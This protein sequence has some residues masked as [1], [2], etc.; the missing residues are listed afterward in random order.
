MFEKCPHNND[1]PCPFA[2]YSLGALRCGEMTGTLDLD[3]NDV[4]LFEVCAR[5][6]IPKSRVSKKVITTN[7]HTPSIKPVASKQVGV[8]KPNKAKKSVKKNNVPKTGSLF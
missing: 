6:K 2:V 5:I 1:K 8:K 3:E 4:S 7:I